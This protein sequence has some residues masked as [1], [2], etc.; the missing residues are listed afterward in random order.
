MNRAESL[1]GRRDINKLKK[2]MHPSARQKITQAKGGGDGEGGVVILYREFR[3]IH[4]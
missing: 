3:A 2:S 4:V 1:V